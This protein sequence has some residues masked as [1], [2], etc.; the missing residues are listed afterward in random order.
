MKWRNRWLAVGFILGVVGTGTLVADTIKHRFVSPVPDAGNPDEVGPDEWNDSLKVD[1]GSDGMSM[2]RDSSQVDGWKWSFVIGTPT[3]TG[4]IPT[5]TNTPTNT[6]TA[7]PTPTNTPLVFST[8]GKIVIFATPEFGAYAGSSPSCP[9]GISELDAFGAPTCINTPTN[10]PTQ[11]P[12]NTPTN[13]PTS[14]NTP[15]VTPTPTSVSATAKPFLYWLPNQATFP[16][17]A[18]PQLALDP[19]SST[20][21]VLAYDA[22]TDECAYFGGVLP[23]SYGGGGLTVDIT[24][25]AVS[26]TSGAVGWRTAFERWD[27]G[28]DIRGANSFGTEK[29]VSTTVNGT[30]GRPTVSTNAHASGAE[31]DSLAAGDAFQIYVCRDADGSSVTDSMAGDAQLVRVDV[32]E[33]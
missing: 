28:T 10:T 7:T 9:S 14:T 26:A 29:Q 30:L 4:T 5:P 1:G 31:I 8:P 27:S 3:P 11:T 13:T 21:N 16:G 20:L 22:S 15:T 19:N 12:T 6:P 17:S 18:Y 2:V 23:A 24:W 32:K 33:P 25:T